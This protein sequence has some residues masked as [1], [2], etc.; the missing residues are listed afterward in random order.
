MIP[1]GALE[2]R[3]RRAVYKFGPVGEDDFRSVM[4]EGSSL[5]FSSCR[6][7]LLVEGEPMRFLIEGGRTWRTT[8][9]IAV[10]KTSV[11]PGPPGVR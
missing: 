8:E 5:P 2:V 7:T 10:T 1:S 4:K 3:T 9:V 6:V 11:V